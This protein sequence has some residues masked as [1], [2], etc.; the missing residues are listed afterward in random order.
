[1]AVLTGTLEIGRQNINELFFIEAERLDKQYLDV[2]G[3]VRR[4]TQ[5]Y[6]QYK[7]LKP[8]AAATQTSEGEE[9]APDDWTP[10][11]IQN[12]TPALFTKLIRYSELFDYTNQY[13]DVINKQDQ[14]ARAFLKA[15]NIG[16]ANLDNLGFTAT[17]YGMNNET[18]YS[19]AH[20]MGVG[21]PTGPNI[22]V[23]PGTTTPLNLAFGPLALEQAMTEVRLQKDPTGAPM[24]LTGKVLLKVPVSLEGVAR[25]VIKS[26]QLAQTSNNDTNEWIR[27]RVELAV[28]DYYTSTNAWFLRMVDNALHHLFILEQL[29][30]R[31][32]Q[33]AMDAACTFKWVARESYIFGWQDWHGT[34]GTA[35]R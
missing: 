9:A 2:V 8:L 35:G 27:N 1:M 30:Y 28:N 7:Q 24:M 3:R 14:F 25:R 19:A 13:K 20:S 21:N 11:F 16:G 32:T 34:W 5:A 29:P 12:F 26:M 23:V 15:R 33:L 10:I 4:T 22:P 6:E 31:C 17:T 18:L